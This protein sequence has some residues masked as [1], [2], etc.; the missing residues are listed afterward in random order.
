MTSHNQEIEIKLAVRSADEARAMLQRLGFAVKTARTFE[1]NEL[2][3]FKS[4]ALRRQ[5]EL[6]RLREYGGEF[7][8][9]YKGPPEPGPY[10]SREE[11]ETKVSDGTRMR[12]L[13]ARLGLQ[14][15]FR[16]EKYRTEW[17]RG[18]EPGLVTLDETPIGAF[19]ELEGLP[20]WIDSTAAALGFRRQDYITASYGGLYLDFCNKNGLTPSH[21]TFPA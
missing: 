21:M 6:L 20:G 7:I 8:V 1:A 18:D 5:R 11:I 12:T 15:T 3:D 13:F 4:G 14:P 10:K 9:T 19:L 2:F 17:S 16:Y